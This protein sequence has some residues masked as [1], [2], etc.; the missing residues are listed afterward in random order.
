MSRSPVP[1][2]LHVIFAREANVGVVIR[3]GPSKQT[4]LILWNTSTD[5]FVPGQWIK[6]RVYERRCDLSPDGKLFVYFALDGHWKGPTGGAFTAVSR[7]PYFTA[8]GLWPQGHTWQGGGLFVK[9][10]LVWID[11]DSDSPL[12]SPAKLALCD[13]NSVSSE[14]SDVR[15]G[16]YILRLRRD[17]W[18]EIGSS[19]AGAR[20]T[21]SWAKRGG[22]PHAL[23]LVRRE[24]ATGEMRSDCTG[25]RFDE[26]EVE[27]GPDGST[28]SLPGVEWADF[29]HR[30]R[31]VYAA[32]GRLWE[33]VIEGSEIRPREIR[34]FRDMKFEA[35]KS[36]EWARRE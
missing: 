25:V 13:G 21:V 3:R 32:D 27:I 10:D 5:E 6:G 31:L 33:G 22:D 12:V 36:P 26:H 11:G 17:G 7:P 30:G 16:V 29:D 14:V 1:S 34:D 28:A 15:L 8:I 23:R 24:I 18:R 4:R 19:Q 9:N 35:I 2:R 20:T